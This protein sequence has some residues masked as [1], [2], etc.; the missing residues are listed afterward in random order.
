MN[1]NICSL[2]LTERKGLIE[3]ALSCGTCLHSA[4]ACG[5]TYFIRKPKARF[6]GPELSSVDPYLG[7]ALDVVGKKNIC[8]P[9]DSHPMLCVVQGFL[10]EMS[11]SEASW[12]RL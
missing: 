3:L 6:Q 12:D 4:N 1:V 8:S 2:P 9:I 5:F 10:L 7:N 11:L